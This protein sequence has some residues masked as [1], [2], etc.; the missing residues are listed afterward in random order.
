MKG[1]TVAFA[2]WFALGRGGNAGNAQQG[3]ASIPC[4]EAAVDAYLNRHPKCG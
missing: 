2:G 4:D 3:P 1:V